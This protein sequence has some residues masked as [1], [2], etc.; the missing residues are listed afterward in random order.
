MV[1]KLNYDSLCTQEQMIFKKILQ[2][3]LK[4][5]LNIQIMN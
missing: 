5:D 4:L 1:R 2:K 3:M